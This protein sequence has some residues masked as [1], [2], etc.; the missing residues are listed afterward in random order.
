MPTPRKRNSAAGFS[1]EEE[2]SV[3]ETTPAETVEE[4]DVVAKEEKPFVLETVQPTE[5]IEK[6]PEPTPVVEP[7]KP[8]T[9]GLTLQ[10]PPKRHPRNIPKF[11]RFK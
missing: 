4:T 10:P 11:S 5:Y 6:A 9:P 7:P 3:V 1:K 2:T 8:A